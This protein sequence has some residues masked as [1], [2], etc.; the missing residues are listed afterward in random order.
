MPIIVV[1]G[2]AKDVGKTTLVCNIVSAFRERGWTAV[3]ISDHRHDVS[4]CKLLAE[5]SGW[6]IREQLERDDTSDTARYLRAGSMRALLVQAEEGALRNAVAALHPFLS[7]NAIIESNRAVE[8]LSPDLF[9]LMVDAERDLKP[10][11]QSQLQRADALVWRGPGALTM[12]KSSFP[13][14]PDG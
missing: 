2:Q 12:M 5:G 9:L 8:F 1:G 13:A 7:G 4:D 3:K 14:L 10:S 6:C 11:A